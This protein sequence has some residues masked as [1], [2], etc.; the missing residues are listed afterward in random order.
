MFGL[1]TPMFYLQTYSTAHG[2]EKSIAFY[3]LSILSGASLFGRL[4]PNWLADSYGPLTILAP[5]CLLSGVFIFLWLPMGK[6]EAGLIVF[7]ILFGF[8]SGC[9]V[10]MQPACIA[11]MTVQMDQI[12]IRTAM[13]FLFTSMAALTVSRGLPVISTDMEKGGL[14]LPDESLEGS[15]S[16]IGN[17]RDAA[18][19]EIDEGSLEK[20]LSS[21]VYYPDGGLR[22]WSVVGGA[23]CVSFCAWG[24][25]NSFGVFQSYYKLNQLRH[26]T[27]SDISWIGAFQLS[28][29][30]FCAILIGKAFDAGHT[31][32]LLVAGTLLYTA[33]LFGLSY[34]TT[35]TEI[36]LAQGVACGAGIAFYALSI[37]SGASLFGR[38][39]PN[40]HCL[41]S[42]IFIFL[43]LPMGKS[44]AGLIVFAILYGYLSG[45]FV[46]MQ[47][48]CIASMTVQMDQIGIRTAMAFIFTSLAA[49]TGT[50]IA[51]AMITA[52]GGSYVGA[53]C[54]SGAMVLFGAFSLGVARQILVRRKGTQWV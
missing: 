19:P 50:P 13:A 8:L 4:I 41:L 31:R 21:E 26:K 9:F 42:G 40:P 43:W 16:T 37:L 49:L 51:G 14:G 44:E 1:Y 35:Y 53:A 33:G 34:A 39:I 45:T 23:W 11:S 24:F 30:T 28:M 6:S 32:F 48:A 7:A 29:V 52:Q 27:A 18:P 47:P 25:C 17:A 54:W 22:A 2:V 36:F 15:L 20:G 5:N 10:S 3:S 38:L 12:G 46:S